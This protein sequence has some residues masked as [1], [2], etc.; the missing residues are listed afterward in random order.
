MDDGVPKLRG[1]LQSGNT[2]NVELLQQHGARTRSQPHVGATHDTN[3]VPDAAMLRRLAKQ[4][5]ALSGT[6]QIPQRPRPPQAGRRHTSVDT[7]A[8]GRVAQPHSPMAGTT[9]LDGRTRS[10]A[11][12]TKTTFATIP[13]G[14]I[15]DIMFSGVDSQGKTQY[16]KIHNQG[17]GSPVAQLGSWSPNDRR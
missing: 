8:L 15:F 14:S 17:M 16:Y 9:R 2:L 6:S 5:L 4:D 12:P 13:Q 3:A 1:K 11:S 7:L 10:P